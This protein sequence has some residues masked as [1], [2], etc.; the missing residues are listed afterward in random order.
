MVRFCLSHKYLNIGLSHPSLFPFTKLIDPQSSAF[1]NRHRTTF[2][3]EEKQ[4][5]KRKILKRDEDVHPNWEAPGFYV[6]QPSGGHGTNIYGY[7]HTDTHAVAG[8][9]V[10]LRTDRSHDLPCSSYPDGPGLSCSRST[11]E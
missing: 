8:S 1:L 10:L 9:P 4:K 7:R 3:Q 6:S 11:A 5:A 2:S